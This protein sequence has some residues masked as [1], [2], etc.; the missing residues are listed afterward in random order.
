MLH[1]LSLSVILWPVFCT[2]N[3]CFTVSIRNDVTEL[4]NACS[5]FLCPQAQ[6]KEV[7]K[8]KELVLQILTEPIRNWE[9]DDIRTLGPVLHMS[10]AAVHSQNC[11]VLIT[12]CKSLTTHRTCCCLSEMKGILKGQL[13]ISQKNLSILVK[14]SV[15]TNCAVWMYQKFIFTPTMNTVQ[16]TVQF[17]FIYTA[18]GTFIVQG[19]PL[20]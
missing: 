7:R 18:L 5:V 4:L 8:K 3:L 14:L 10:Q 9:G 2:F 20:Q 15:Y 11:P 17:N 19:K 6:C 12:T 1:F 13:L 16:F